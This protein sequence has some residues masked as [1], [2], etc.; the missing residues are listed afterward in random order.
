MIAALATL[1]VS[2]LAGEAL[3]RIASLPVPGPV[4]GMILLFAL[5]LARMPLPPAL[6]E[7]ADG[8][9]RHLSLLF[10]PAGAGVVQHLDR[11]GA[12]GLRLVAIVV[13]TTGV[14]LAVTALVFEWVARL[15][16]VDEVP[17]DGAPSDGR[18]GSAQ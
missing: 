1:L 6:G 17:S 13:L 7:A 14:T 4:V 16:G 9:L 15:M 5:L 3:V 12:D 11:L 8:L 10:V 2:Q 18:S